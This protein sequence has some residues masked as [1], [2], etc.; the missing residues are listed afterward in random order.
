M[1]R[2][3]KYLP[4]DAIGSQNSIKESKILRVC[5]E[6]RCIARLVLTVI[7]KVLGL[8]KV[9]IATLRK[10]IEK[11]CELNDQS[12]KIYSKRQWIKLG[13]STDLE[14]VESPFI[15]EILQAP[16]PSKFIMLEC[17]PYNRSGDPIEHLKNY[18]TWMELHG[19][20]GSIM[21]KGFQ[22]TLFGTSRQWYRLL[23]SCFISSFI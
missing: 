18:H 16:F 19:A 9:P 5:R 13:T 7:I 14:K 4:Q 23:K 11:I 10:A 20:T 12:F 8:L 15:E 21:C 17:P 6:Q 2:V 1:E 3:L 22:L